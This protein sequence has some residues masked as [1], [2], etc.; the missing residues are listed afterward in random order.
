MQKIKYDEA[1]TGMRNSAI[2][3]VR[4][5][6]SDF[7][8]ALVVSTRNGQNCF[9]ESVSSSVFSSDCYTT[10]RKIAVVV[11]MNINKSSAKIRWA[12]SRCLNEI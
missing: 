9:E 4:V 3:A 11:L 12:F 10:M 2:D 1:L 5:T 7:C 6:V 8:K